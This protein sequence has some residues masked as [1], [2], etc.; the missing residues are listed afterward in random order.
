MYSFYL[1]HIVYF[2]VVLYGGVAHV[3]PPPTAS[4]TVLAAVRVAAADI[5]D[6]EKLRASPGAR[7]WH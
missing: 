1:K 4:V 6:A 5:E 3:T 2:L 7:V